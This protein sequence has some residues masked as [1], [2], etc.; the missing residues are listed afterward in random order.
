MSIFVICCQKL[1][2]ENHIARF[3]V[4]YLNLPFYRKKFIITYAIVG[5]NYP[6]S[7]SLMMLQPFM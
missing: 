3:G 2:Y 7:T 6:N 5:F 4:I 1:P